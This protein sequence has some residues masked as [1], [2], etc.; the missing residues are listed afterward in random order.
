M[1]S[2]GLSSVN[3]KVFRELTKMTA[4]SALQ[5]NHFAAKEKQRFLRHQAAQA[6]FERQKKANE[7]SK[8]AGSI[9]LASPP[10]E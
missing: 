4:F 9:P 1:K 5:E 7:L 8:D 2:A 3:R 10:S 6:Q